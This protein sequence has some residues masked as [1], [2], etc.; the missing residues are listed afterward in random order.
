MQVLGVLFM[1]MG[2][3]LRVGRCLLRF[4]WPVIALL[5]VAPLVITWSLEVFALNGL[6]LFS[7]LVVVRQVLK[8]RQA[9]SSQKARPARQGKE[10]VMTTQAITMNGGAVR[11][12]HSLEELVDRVIEALF[13]AQEEES[14]SS[15]RRRW[16]RASTMPGG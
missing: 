1:V 6:G 4:K 11:T 9:G 3:A 10:F 13:G 7:G 2:A 8:A 14:R 5:V 16:R 12:R 15:Q